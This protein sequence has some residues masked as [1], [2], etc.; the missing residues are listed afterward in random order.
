VTKRNWSDEESKL[1]TWA[2]Q[3]YSTKKSIKAENFTQFDW[4]NIANLVPGRSDT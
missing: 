3:K 4:Q 2:I 1:L